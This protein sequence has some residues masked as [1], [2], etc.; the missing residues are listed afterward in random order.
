MKNPM[1]ALAILAL[2]TLLSPLS[3]SA[4]VVTRAEWIPGT[5]GRGDVWSFVCP[6][7]GTF[8]LTVQ[9]AADGSGSNIDFFATVKDSTGAVVQFDDDGA[10]CS[11]M[12]SCAGCPQMVA[13]PCTAGGTYYAQI[14]PIGICSVTAGLGGSYTLTLEVKDSAAVSLDAKK[15]KLGGGPKAKVPSWHSPY[16]NP[17]IDDAPIN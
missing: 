8:D 17:L 6:A 10:V 11:S 9:N 12:P 14:F 2:A 15:V 1:Q 13:V 16:S 4:E 5:F 7:G 3:A